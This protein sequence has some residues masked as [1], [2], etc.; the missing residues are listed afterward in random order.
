VR[1]SILLS[2]A[3][4]ERSAVVAIT[5]LKAMN[6]AQSALLVLLARAA[7]DR[8][9]LEIAAVAAFSASSVVVAVT[10]W[11]RQRLVGWAIALDASVGCVVLAVAPLFQPTGRAWSEWPI[12]VSFLVAAEVAIAFRPARATLATLSL[13]AANT[14][15]LLWDPPARTHD[16][17]VG[18]LVAY[19]G[20]AAVAGWFVWYLRKLADL[21]D[22]RAETI[23]QL[24]EERT[25]RL[26]HTPYRLLN[27]LAAM[28]RH[29]SA[30]NGGDP[31]RQA[32]LAEAVASVR[33]IES[34]VRGT[35]PASTNLAAELLRLREQFADLPLVISVEDAQL[36]L[37][38][39]TVYRVR[40]AVRS[41]LQN[42]RLHA[43]ATS[44]VLYAMTDRSGWLV[45]VCDDG[46]GF[47]PAARRG[48]GI[49]DLMIGALT[50]INASVSV[51]SAPGRGTFIEFKGDTP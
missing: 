8:L 41:A 47:D 49:Q 20:F 30:R 12:N 48:V 16:A 7:S 38:P 43:D 37:P 36:G 39:S 28:L 34:V 2:R 40:E 24:E 25:R 17:V 42:V 11:R 13:M 26:L 1:R 46:R 35:E 18:H 5:G 50:G 15:W 31:A 22:T 19:A 29:E 33:E 21:A 23:Q 44:V 4:V 10:S 6:V 32:R 27:D 9:L 3:G 45:S 51:D 14:S